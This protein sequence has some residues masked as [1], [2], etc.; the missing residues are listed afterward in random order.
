[1]K[2]KQRDLISVQY[3]F[4]QVTKLVIRTTSRVEYIF[5]KL[6]NLSWNILGKIFKLFYLLKCCL[7]KRNQVCWLFLVSVLFLCGDLRAKV[8]MLQDYFCKKYQIFN[9]FSFV[10]RHFEYLFLFHFLQICHFPFLYLKHF[11]IIY[12]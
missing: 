3:L 6:F 1:M 4:A 9:I 12:H 5:L 11:I 7:L 8:C 2:F 10:W